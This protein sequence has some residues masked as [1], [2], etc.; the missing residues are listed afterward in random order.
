M[1]LA[2][3]H[4]VSIAAGTGPAGLHEDRCLIESHL[5]QMFAQRTSC[6]DGVVQ[7]AI[8]YAVLGPAQR[9]RPILAL[10]VARV[11]HPSNAAA[12]LD[13][14]IKTALSLELLHCASLVID[15]L[16]CMD[17]SALRRGEPSL[18]VKFGEA[19]AVLAAFALVAQ[20]ARILVEAEC[21][22]EFRERLIQFQI[23]LLRSLDCSGLIA[24]QA[25]DLHLAGQTDSVSQSDISEL[26]TVPLFMLA[27]SA[28]SLCADLDPNQKAL[29]NGFGREFGLAFQM[30][31]DVLDNEPADLS[32]LH[33]KLT[34]LRAVVAPFGVARGKLEELV[35]YLHARVAHSRPK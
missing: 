31:D 34:T 11:V 35:D 16:P 8:R 23:A 10:R 25:L 9:I 6:A 17:N 15:D 26:K 14:T 30:T 1:A 28:G 33:D 27:I 12:E 20:A 18:H 7:Q 2:T 24:G 13:L 4:E 22:P 5:R 21:A 3:L 29:L 32:L 19:T